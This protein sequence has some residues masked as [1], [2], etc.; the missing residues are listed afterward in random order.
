MQQNVHFYYAANGGIEVLF[1]KLTHAYIIV[2]ALHRLLGV[3]QACVFLAG[4]YLL[5]KKCW[6]FVL[7]NLIQLGI[8]KRFK[9]IP[10]NTHSLTVAA[11]FIVILGQ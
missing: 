5:F 3:S 8:Y 9:Y 1:C 4:R 6:L 2:M 7:L 10:I 11:I